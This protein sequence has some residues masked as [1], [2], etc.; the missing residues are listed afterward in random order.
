MP[1]E[2]ALRGGMQVMPQH[3]RITLP[4]VEDTLDLLE[5]AN[6]HD[7]LDRIE[8]L[9]RTLVV[10]DSFLVK[11]DQ[12]PMARQLRRAFYKYTERI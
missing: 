3:R 12:T 9:L 2:R 8:D 5:H 4:E 7:E 11:H 6:H 1:F 10:I